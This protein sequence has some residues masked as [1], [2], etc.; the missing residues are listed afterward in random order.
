MK[1]LKTKYKTKQMPSGYGIVQRSV[2]QL[3]DLSRE[4][5]LIYSLLCTYSGAKD[6][7]FPSIKTICKDL[8]YSE[9]SKDSISK[10]LKELEE[11]GLLE[12]SKLYPHDPIKNNNKY[13]L[14]ML[15]QSE[16]CHR[17]SSLTASMQLENN[18][19]GSQ[20]TAYKINSIKNNIYTPPE[21]ELTPTKQEKTPF[22]E[23]NAKSCNLTSKAKKDEWFMVPKK[24]AHNF[25]DSNNIGFL[26]QPDEKIIVLLPEY[27]ENNEKREDL[28]YDI[29]QVF[30]LAKAEKISSSLMSKLKN[31]NYILEKF[32][33]KQYLKGYQLAQKRNKSDKLSY[34]KNILYRA[35]MPTVYKNAHHN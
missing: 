19:G 20:R 17:G 34:L 9:K 18:L 16:N 15:E 11:T 6:F 5:K 25:R 30:R 27:L 21:G 12:I 1:K 8:N 28:E 13:R 33:L 24:M 4:A 7:C 2:M 31:I 32:D 3:D 14:M 29:D 22:Q 23:T 35:F 10:F 26:N